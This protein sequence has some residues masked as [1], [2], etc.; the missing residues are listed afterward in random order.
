MNRLLFALLSFVVAGAL[1]LSEPFGFSAGLF[2][3]DS[4]HAKLLIGPEL[5]NGA[6][7]KPGQLDTPF[8]VD[9]DAAGNMLIAE[10]DGGRVH[11]IDTDGKFE[12]IAGDGKKGAEGDGGPAKKAR[13][14]GMHNLAVLPNGDIFIADTW[15]QRVRKIDH[16]TGVITTI[17]GTGKAGFGGDGGPAEKATFRDIMCISLNPTNDHLFIAD[18]KNHRIRAIDLKTNTIR[19]VAGNGSKGVPQ[20]G[21]KAVDAPLV[22]PRAVAVDSQNRI[23]ILERGGHALRRVLTDGTIETVVGT[24]KSGKATGPALSAQLSGPKH[25]AIDSDDNVYIAD[26]QNH[27]ICKYD[28]EAKQLDVI[29]GAGVKQPHAVLRRPHGVCVRKDGSLIVVDSYHHRIFELTFD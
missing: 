10:F 2:A 20:D 12:T 26:E 16:E 6:A 14:N 25:I 27:R 24:G 9:F 29:F 13:F 23:Y 17:A 28:A 5:E 1:L 7:P 3:A 22:D 8:G 21:A 19:T 11:R 15:N 4:V 18:L